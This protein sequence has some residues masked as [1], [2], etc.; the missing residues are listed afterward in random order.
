MEHGEKATAGV[1]RGNLRT[2]HV[3]A[4]FFLFFLQDGGKRKNCKTQDFQSQE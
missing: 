1:D 2:F 4:C 3:T